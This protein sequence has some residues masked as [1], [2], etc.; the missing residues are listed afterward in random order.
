MF[1]HVRTA[2]PVPGRHPLRR[3]RSHRLPVRRSGRATRFREAIQDAVEAL[4]EL[5]GQDY[6]YLSLSF[7][8][9]YALVK[10]DRRDPWFVTD[11]LL[12]DE[13]SKAP[14]AGPA[15]ARVFQDW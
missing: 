4:L 10:E 13:F 6:R 3:A 9:P 7:L 12:A 1:R 11:S 14:G 8:S 5:P 15:G 2:A